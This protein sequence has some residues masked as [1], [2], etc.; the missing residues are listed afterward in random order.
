M[1]QSVPERR[2]GVVIWPVQDLSYTQVFGGFSFPSFLFYSYFCPI[3]FPLWL[4]AKEGNLNPHML[5]MQRMPGIPPRPYSSVN[6]TVYHLF[7]SCSFSS[8]PFWYNTFTTQ[9]L[10]P[11]IPSCQGPHSLV[12]LEALITQISIPPCLLS[13]LAVLCRIFA[14]YSWPHLTP[15][16]NTNMHKTPLW[17]HAK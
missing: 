13:P 2:V 17:D 8:A 16:L 7:L 15:T 12:C 6:R 9:E 4:S 10:P 1:C 3:I 14:I 11:S 5:A